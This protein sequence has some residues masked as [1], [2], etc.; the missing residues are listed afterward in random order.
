MLI[1][2]EEPFDSPTYLHSVVRLDYDPYFTSDNKIITTKIYNARPFGQ[3]NNIYFGS[4]GC[5][6]PKELTVVDK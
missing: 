4:A 3:S 5:S 6:S 2:W 1:V